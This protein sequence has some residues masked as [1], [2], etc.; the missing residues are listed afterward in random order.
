MAD[1]GWWIRLLSDNE[2]ILEEEHFIGDYHPMMDRLQ[3][4][5]GNA[6][7]EVAGF[8]V[9]AD[10]AMQTYMVRV[11]KANQVYEDD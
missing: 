4:L 7:N 8:T 3:F 11:E 2:E 10:L 9:I 6:G 5:W 1:G